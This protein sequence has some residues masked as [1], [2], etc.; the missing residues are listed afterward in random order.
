MSEIRCYFCNLVCLRDSEASFRCLNHGISDSIRHYVYQNAP[1]HN[2]V[3][4]SK[5]NKDK[6]IAIY[7][8]GINQKYLKIRISMPPVY[9]K[10]K[11]LYEGEMPRDFAPESAIAFSN[12]LLKLKAFL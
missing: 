6:I 4:F 3:S 7:E 11:Y 10:T 2:W 9:A 8:V 12:K 1:Q 5:I